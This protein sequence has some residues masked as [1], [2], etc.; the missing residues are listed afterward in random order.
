LLGRN[1]LPSI[2]W[3]PGEEAAVSMLAV[4]ISVVFQFFPG[5]PSTGD[6]K[7]LV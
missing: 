6:H 4:N 2:T 5:R 7:E 3:S 1:F